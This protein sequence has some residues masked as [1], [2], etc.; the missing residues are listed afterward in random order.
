MIDNGEEMTVQKTSVG[1]VMSE[2]I[3]CD[4]KMLGWTGGA[5][6]VA[7]RMPDTLDAGAAPPASKPRPK[8]AET[9]L[10]PSKVRVDCHPVPPEQPLSN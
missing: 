7:A 1:G 4:S 2:G 6:G 3:F 9:E 8:E 5:A 10:A